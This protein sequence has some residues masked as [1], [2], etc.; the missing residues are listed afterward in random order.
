MSL[1]YSSYLK[2]DELLD[3][4]GEQEGAGQV[5]ERNR[6]CHPWIPGQRAWK[7]CEQVQCQWGDKNTSDLV[8]DIDDA[9]GPVIGRCGRCDV[10]N[11]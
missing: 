8:Q 5:E 6:P 2:L 1:T 3:L 4:Q 9:A 7:D 10:Q 11:R